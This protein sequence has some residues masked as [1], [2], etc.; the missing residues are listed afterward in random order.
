M[1]AAESLDGCALGHVPNADAL[2]LCNRDNQLL[3]LME[4]CARD[5]VRVSAAS[6]D[7]PC[8]GFYF[9]KR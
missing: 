5:I 2:V 3:S 1:L 6:V 4:N 9:S 7:L 8:L